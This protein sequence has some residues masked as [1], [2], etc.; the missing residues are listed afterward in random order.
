MYSTVQFNRSNSKWGENVSMLL[1]PKRSWIGIL[2][3]K[4]CWMYWKSPLLLSLDYSA[5]TCHF[6]EPN[7]ESLHSYRLPREPP[8]LNSFILCHDH[9]HPFWLQVCQEMVV[10]SVSLGTRCPSYLFQNCTWHFNIPNLV[11]VIHCVDFHTW[12]RYQ[13]EFNVPAP[14]RENIS[15]DWG[16]KKC[17]KQETW[18]KR[19]KLKNSAIWIFCKR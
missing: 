16:F 1:T 7:M 14:K 8:D 18:D 2:H 6:V 15:K 5:L 9:I 11:Y 12:V 17:W 13:V 19:N 10:Q 4:A 3:S